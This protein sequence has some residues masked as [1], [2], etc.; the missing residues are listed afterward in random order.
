VPIVLVVRALLAAVTLA[1]VVGLSV[2]VTSGPAD[3]GVTVVSAAPS[4]VSRHPEKEEKNRNENW[5][6]NNNNNGNS[7]G[8][9]NQND[10]GNSVDDGDDDRG[11]SAENRRGSQPAAPP[12]PASTAGRCFAAGQSGTLSLILDGGTVTLNV[13]SGSAFPRDS[14][15]TLGKVDPA[16]VPATPGP[17]LDE[18]VFEIR[19]QE[20]C[21]GSALSELPA[22]ANLGV[23]YRVPA[24][25]P[26]VRI[27]FLT[28][29]DGGTWVDVPTV[30]DPSNPYVSATVRRTGVY[31]VYQA[32]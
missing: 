10:N 18:L 15:V 21:D 32:R 9:S 25:K 31:T 14:R 19:A 2:L 27:A 12:P 16:S 13:V 3:G 7:N 30:P 22:D 17:R 29:G 26:T 28:G 6:G 23:S 4:N 1:I 20:G 11:S 5:N 24:D 8:N